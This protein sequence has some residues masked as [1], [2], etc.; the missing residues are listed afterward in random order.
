MSL[1]GSHR[2]P[3]GAKL[4]LRRQADQCAC[5]HR[6]SSGPLE[7]TEGK[8]AQYTSRHTGEISRHKKARSKRAQ[9][10]KEKT[11]RLPRV[12]IESEG[13]EAPMESSARRCLEASQSKTIIE[14]HPYLHRH[15]SHAKLECSAA[16]GKNLGKPSRSV[17]K[18]LLAKH[19]SNPFHGFWQNN[20]KLSTV[21]QNPFFV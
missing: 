6:C 21:Q 17:S 11:A 20:N 7:A 19:T 18:R 10:G 4:R 16:G 3:E 13:G 12:K 8:R 5:W 15:A 14:G 2:S 9:T 1:T